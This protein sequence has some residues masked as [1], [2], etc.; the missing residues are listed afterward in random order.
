MTFGEKFKAGR[1]RLHLTQQEIADRLGLNRRMITRYENDISLPRTR[2]AYRRIAELL[3]VDINY[4]LSEDQEFVVSASEKYGDRGKKEAQEL[5]AHMSGLFAG[6]TL[7]EQDKDAVM[8]ALQDI[9]WQSKEQNI[10]RYTP[11]KYRKETK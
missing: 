3:E 10:A 2:D 11:R 9:Y 8:K 5:I 6:G 1:E 7:S 4:L